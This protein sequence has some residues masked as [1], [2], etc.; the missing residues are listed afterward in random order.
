MN[1]YQRVQQSINLIERDVLENLSIEQLSEEA[2]M[3]TSNFYR[4]FFS[5]TGYTVK[6]YIRH[7]SMSEISNHLIKTSRSIIDLA[8]EMGFSSQESFSKSFKTVTGMTPYECR[9]NKKK[10]HF[11]EIDLMSREF[12]NQSRELQ[13]R[14]P[15]IKVLKKLPNMRVK[16]FKSHSDSPESDCWDKMRDWAI[17]NNQWAENCNSRVFGFDIDGGYELWLQMPDGLRI[18][19]SSEL[20]EVDEASYAVM[21]INVKSGDEIGNCWDR[22]R[23]W[24]ED[25]PFKNGNHQWLEEHLELKQSNEFPLKMDLYYPIKK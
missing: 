21:G 12:D 3:S 15:D 6:K 20:L 4:M 25:S 18:T 17:V 19:G 9:K 13:D 22:F 23:S 7:R 14:Y 10:Y 8:I 11:K 16:S 1:Y 24:L 2:Y 5:L